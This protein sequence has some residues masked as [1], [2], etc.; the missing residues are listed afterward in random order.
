MCTIRSITYGAASM[1][2]NS[3]TFLKIEATAELKLAVVA[4]AIIAVVVTIITN[5]WVHVFRMTHRIMLKLFI[6]IY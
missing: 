4:A 2:A 6:H 5:S 3:P 1:A